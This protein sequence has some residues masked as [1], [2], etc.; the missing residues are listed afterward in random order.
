MQHH[1]LAHWFQMLIAYHN[2]ECRIK[3]SLSKRHLYTSRS[4]LDQH[5][6]ILSAPRCLSRPTSRYIV[7]THMSIR[8][9]ISIYCLHSDFYQDQHLYILSALRCLL[10]PT[11]IYIVYTQMSIR[12]NISIYCL[13]SDVYQDQRRYIL[14]AFRCLS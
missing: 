8:T 11:Y 2:D 3:Y 13:H 1:N 9:N 7:C 10:R 12:T 6:Y 14:S 4:S 5:L